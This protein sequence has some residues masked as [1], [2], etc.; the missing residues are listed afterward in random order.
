M[1]LSA[2]VDGR[3]CIGMDLPLDEWKILQTKHRKGQLPILMIGCKQ[4]GHMVRKNGLQFF[5][6]AANSQKCNCECE[7]E[8]HL[9]LKYAIYNYCLKQG[10]SADTEYSA[11]DYSW[12]ADIFTWNADR[13][14]AIEIQLS[15]ISLD[16]LIDRD[17][18]YSTAGI[19][20]YWILWDFPNGWEMGGKKKY[21]D[22]T[23]MDYEALDNKK[24][25]G[26]E[27]I[28][29]RESELMQEIRFFVYHKIITKKNDPDLDI[30]GLVS[31]FLKQEYR[32]NFLKYESD[33]NRYIIFKKEFVEITEYFTSQKLVL[34]YYREKVYK[35]DFFLKHYEL[36]YDSELGHALK[37][38]HSNLK[39]CSGELDHFFND[40]K[41]KI[42]SDYSNVELFQQ[43]RDRMIKLNSRLLESLD[44]VEW[45]MKNAN[46]FSKL[47]RKELKKMGLPLKKGQTQLSKF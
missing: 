35:F 19:E 20:S 1:P 42:F 43:K 38:A 30:S 7:S 29:F 4:P 24:V 25:I 47:K 14:L 18:K 17:K 34:D 3:K 41:L 6:H 31:S 27:K 39:E 16:T 44:N 22:L 15:P 5:R 13:K 23:S 40:S 2:L 46:E 37:K 21:D 12:R 10:W 33:I 11:P 9:R 28:I 32:N 36:K 26:R 45:I 8:K